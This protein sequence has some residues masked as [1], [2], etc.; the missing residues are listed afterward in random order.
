MDFMKGEDC[1][2]PERIKRRNLE[3]F[4]LEEGIFREQVRNMS[5]KRCCFVDIG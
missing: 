5:G 2:I 1:G 4:D 3:K